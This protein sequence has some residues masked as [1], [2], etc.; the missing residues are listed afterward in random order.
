MAERISHTAKPIPTR[1]AKTQATARRRKTRAATGSSES[2][3]RDI[4]RTVPAGGN[5]AA[6]GAPEE[7]ELPKEKAPPEGR[8]ST[9]RKGVAG[10]RRGDGEAA[11]GQGGLSET[12]AAR[13]ITGKAATPR[14]DSLEIPPG[15]SLAAA[16]RLEELAGAKAAKTVAAI[17]ARP[18]VVQRYAEGAQPNGEVCAEFLAQSVR[19]GVDIGDLFTSEAFKL[20]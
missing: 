8:A 14:L 11:A 3:G 18:E 17:A 9:R 7:K 19:L 10:R 2:L 1:A 15:I 5:L 16:A 6:G 13:T 4:H 12:E 20:S